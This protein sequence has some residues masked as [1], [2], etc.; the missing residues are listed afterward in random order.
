MHKSFASQNI[1]DW[2]EKNRSETKQC[3]RFLFSVDLLDNY[4]RLDWGFEAVPV[5]LC[6]SILTELQL[7]FSFALRWQ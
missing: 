2:R 5:F 7:C 4:C 6:V 1:A 3:I